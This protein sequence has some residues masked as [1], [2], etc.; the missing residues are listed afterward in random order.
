L[1]WSHTL[2]HNETVGAYPPRLTASGDGV[3]Y[4]SVPTM[5]P[6]ASSLLAFKV[7]TGD[8]VFNTTIKCHVAGELVVSPH[9]S[10]YFPVVGCAGGA[11]QW[12]IALAV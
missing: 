1:L 7:T 3:V 6:P 4:V 9:G 2:R 8:L 11:D 10:L 5:T 12:S